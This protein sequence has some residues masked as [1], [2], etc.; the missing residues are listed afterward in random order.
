[1]NLMRLFASTVSLVG[2][3]IFGLVVVD[4]Y[5]GILAGEF[6]PDAAHTTAHHLGGFLLALA[7]P[8]HVIFI[9]FI[10]QRHWLSP[11]WLRISRVGIVASGLWLGVALVVKLYM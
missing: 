8:L 5:N 7:V 9:G 11:L 4:A 3:C 10:L 1:M 6:F 2:L